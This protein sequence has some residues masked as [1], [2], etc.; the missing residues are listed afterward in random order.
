MAYGYETG[1]TIEY[2]PTV[3]KKISCK[4]CV[5]YDKSDKSCQKRPVYLPE[6][7][8]GLWMTCSYFEL[9]SSTFNYEKKK[10]QLSRKKYFQESKSKSASL[11]S[12]NNEPF[13]SRE[14]L[15]RVGRTVKHS[16]YGMGVVTKYDKDY[17]YVRFKTK[18]TD[19]KLSINT[20]IH[21]RLIQLS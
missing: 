21:K 8:Y 14:K 11:S 18:R 1:F 2:D 12:K 10:L 5:N 15:C 4:D 20:I 16:I 9:D 19:V 3:K 7:G 6:D 13:I 17:I